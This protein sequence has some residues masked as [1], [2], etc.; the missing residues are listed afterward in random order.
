MKIIGSL[1]NDD[2]DGNENGKKAIGLISKTTTLL[3][4]QAF[5]CTFLCRPCTTHDVKLPN[6][7]FYGGCEHKTTTLFFCS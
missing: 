5:F 4:Q 6:L 2:G 3:V 1:S 7:T